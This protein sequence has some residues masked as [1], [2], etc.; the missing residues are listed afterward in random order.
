METTH[1]SYSAIVLQLETHPSIVCFVILEQRLTNCI[2]LLPAGFLLGSA[3]G[4]TRGRL[5]AGLEEEEGT[6]F[7][8]GAS[9]RFH[10]H[11]SL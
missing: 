3:N 8:L 11:I 4:D 5:T 1:V 10:I 6:C 7:Y 9:C 2:S